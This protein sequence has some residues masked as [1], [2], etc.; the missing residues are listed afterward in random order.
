MRNN[1]TAGFKYFDFKDVKSISI[2]LRG[3]AKG[4]FEVR[5][6]REG[7]VLAKIPV[8]FTNV[9]ETYKSDISIPDGVGAIFLTYKG[10]GA[11]D[12]QGF[13]LA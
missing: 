4:E 13:E 1:A 3:Y 7:E 8:D 2:T 10:G 9:W 12:L 6:S 11:C 5:T